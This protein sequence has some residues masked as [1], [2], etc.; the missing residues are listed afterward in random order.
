MR[1]SASTCTTVDLSHPRLLK[2]SQTCSSLSLTLFRSL[3]FCPAIHSDL[4]YLP[5]TLFLLSSSNY[6]IA[7]CDTFGRLA[8]LTWSL[9][10]AGTPAT[11]EES[12]PVPEQGPTRDGAAAHS[13]SPSGTHYLSTGSIAFPNLTLRVGNE[14]IYQSSTPNPLFPLSH[15]HPRAHWKYQTRQNTFLAN[16]SRS[17]CSSRCPRTARRP[18]TLHLRDI[19]VVLIYPTQHGPRPVHRG[20]P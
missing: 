7:C 8:D 4:A 2:P 1:D 17:L 9:R 14:N 20:V 13:S 19:R 3:P 10:R 11:R 16:P 18:I 12:L 6:L 5:F 15:A